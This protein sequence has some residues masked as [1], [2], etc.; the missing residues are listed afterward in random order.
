VGDVIVA[1][2]GKTA[3]LTESQFLTLIRLNY[4]PKDPMKLTIQ[5]GSQ[6][7]EISVLAW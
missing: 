4:G 5:R 3:P 1:V 7:E 2:D 6:R